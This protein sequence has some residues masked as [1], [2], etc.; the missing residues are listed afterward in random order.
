M[1]KTVV[2]Q[3]VEEQFA[4][5]CGHLPEEKDKEEFYGRGDKCNHN[6]DEEF[7]DRNR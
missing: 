5:S 3:V 2:D 1:V 6:L 4:G 7:K